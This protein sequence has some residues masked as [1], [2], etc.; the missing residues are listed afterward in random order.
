MN[1]FELFGLPESFFVSQYHLKQKYFELSKKFHP[2][3]FG[4]ADSEKQEEA[5]EQTALINKAY[6]TLS[7]HFATLQYILELRGII[8]EDEKH[9][10]PA[11]F[12]M[13]MMELNEELAEAKLLQDN[14]KL[15]NIKLKI[16]FDANHYY[17]KIHTVLQAY[18]KEA[19]TKES[20]LPV[21]DYYYKQKYMNR[22]LDSL[23]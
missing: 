21:K 1:Y 4:D 11:N 18:D 23:K 20:L 9:N 6:K 7:S 19:F 22:I 3:Y 13:E 16:E 14:E 17:K 5:L 2:D 8:E 10:L 15:D 12:L